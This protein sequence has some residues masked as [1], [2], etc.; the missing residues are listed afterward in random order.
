MNI[1]AAQFDEFTQADD[2]LEELCAVRGFAPTDVA[3]VVLGA[4]GRHDA[5]SIGGD[6]EEDAGA[7]K[8]DR[9]ATSGA[10]MGG[11]AG[12][13]AGIAAAIALGPVA[14]VA[15]TAIGAYTGSLAGALDRMTDVSAQGG[16]PARPAGVMVMAHATTPAR[17]E[18]ALAVFT[19]HH[20][21]GI[22]EAEGQWSNGTWADFNPVSRPNWLV[23]PAPLTDSLAT[24]HP[25]A[26]AS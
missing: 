18:Q 8:G 9:G 3:K 12:A 26:D 24:T 21:R 16:T 19:H 13:V 4:P 20:A 5:F 7:S 10:V 15:A 14:A 23:P 25:R 22:E 6:E 17:R 11:G 1:L 2:A